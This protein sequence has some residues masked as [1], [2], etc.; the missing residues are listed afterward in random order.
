MALYTDIFGRLDW[1]TTRVK[2]LCCAVDKNTA[3]IAAAEVANP[4]YL[5]I[6]TDDVRSIQ[7]RSL[8]DWNANTI[9]STPFTAYVEIGDTIRLY[10][11]SNVYLPANIFPNNLHLISINDGCGAITSL[12]TGVFQDC[13][14]LVYVNL[15]VLTEISG[16]AFYRCSGL[17]YINTP[18]ATTIGFESFTLCTSLVSV[19]FPSATS[20]EY[21]VF[22]SCSVLTIVN[23]PVVTNL[24]GSPGLEYVFKSI[25]GN[26]MTLTVP[27]AQQFINSGNPDE[28]IVYFLGNNPGSTV[29]YI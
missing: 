25:S 2:R 16:A 23:L 7:Y 21:S 9:W 1:L 11:G 13:S 27:V 12:E 4:C 20:L 15:P 22:D 6:V 8:A 28:D 19:S 29:N 14:N 26:I 5:E 18:L 3:A 17:T 10:G 24:G